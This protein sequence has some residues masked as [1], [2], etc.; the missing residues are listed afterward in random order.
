LFSV[1]L[2]QNLSNVSF[3]SHSSNDMADFVSCRAAPDKLVSSSL[4]TRITLHNPLPIW[5]HAYVLPFVPLY[6][7]FAT[8]YFFYYDK[9]I[10]SEEWTFVYF[11]SIITLNALAWLSIHWS[12]TLN[13]L[14]T[15]RTVPSALLL[16][17]IPGEI[18]RGCS[19]S[20]SRTRSKPRQSR[21]LQIGT[22]HCT[23]HRSNIYLTHK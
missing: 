18:R 15:A 8:I 1:C 13:A 14:F 16:P 7:L 19:S 22:Y 20:Q 11:G 9:Y 10:A 6:P 5:A 12:V 2:L 3:S 23:F 21:N 4:I 17:L